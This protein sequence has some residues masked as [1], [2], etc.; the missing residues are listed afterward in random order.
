MRHGAYTFQELWEPLSASERYA[1]LC[2]AVL[3]QARTTVALSHI[4]SA[5]EWGAPL[6][7][8]DLSEVH[9]T[10]RDGKAGRRGSRREASIAAT[11]WTVT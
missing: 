6:W 4:S 7:D 9:L 11:F 5:N 1:L 2:A 8:V 3:R 10:R